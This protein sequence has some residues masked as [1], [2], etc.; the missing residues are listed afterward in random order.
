MQIYRRVPCW[1][2]SEMERCGVSDDRDDACSAGWPALFDRRDDAE[3][4]D[5]AAMR[6]LKE[7][8]TEGARRMMH[9]NTRR[10]REHDAKISACGMP[11]FVR[12]RTDALV[13]LPTPNLPGDCAAD[14]GVSSRCFLCR[15]STVTPLVS[16]LPETLGRLSSVVGFVPFRYSWSMSRSAR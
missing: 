5:V 2:W 7:R 15:S 1:F 9:M 10:Q 8:Y 6:M 4:V 14:T 3:R 12:F 11:L 13:I 16:C